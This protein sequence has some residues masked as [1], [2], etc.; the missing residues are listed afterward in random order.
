[1]GRSC[2]HSILAL[3]ESKGTNIHPYSV[4]PIH[5][6]SYTVNHFP[7]VAILVQQLAA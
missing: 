6:H 5:K 3:A 1:V 7:H 2:I 4:L